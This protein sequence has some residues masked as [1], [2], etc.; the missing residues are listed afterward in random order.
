MEM[1]VCPSTILIGEKYL[2]TIISHIAKK[3]GI[4]IQPP[5][6]IVLTDFGDPK[7][8]ILAH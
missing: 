2:L 6:K 4:V 3:L 7:H 1:L 5:Q 8:L